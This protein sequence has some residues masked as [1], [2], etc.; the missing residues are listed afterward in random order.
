MVLPTWTTAI[1]VIFVANIVFFKAARKF[2]IETL[3]KSSGVVETSAMIR[4]GVGN[5][6][7]DGFGRCGLHLYGLVVP[8][9]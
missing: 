6:V 1:L 4:G 7:E 5:F 2:T 9:V 3:G 8:R